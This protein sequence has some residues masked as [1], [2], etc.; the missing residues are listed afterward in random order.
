MLYSLYENKENT[1]ILKRINS[2]GFR[3]LEKK[4]LKEEFELVEREENK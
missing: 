3:I 4:N 2:Q 1:C